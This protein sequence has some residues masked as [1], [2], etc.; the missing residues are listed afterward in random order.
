MHLFIPASSLHKSSI[1]Q[2]PKSLQ[3]LQ[4]W[5]QQVLSQVVKKS[6]WLQW[7]PESSGARPWWWTQSMPRA[8]WRQFQLGRRSPCCEGLAK[9]CPCPE[10]GEEKSSLAEKT[11]AFWGGRWRIINPQIPPTRAGWSKTSWWKDLCALGYGE[12]HSSPLPT[13]KAQ[14]ITAHQATPH[15]LILIQ[16]PH[17]L[18]CCHLLH[19][20][21]EESS[22]GEVHLF[23]PWGKEH[24]FILYAFDAHTSSMTS[25]CTHNMPARLDHI[26]SDL[27]VVWSGTFSTHCTDANRRETSFGSFQ[28]VTCAVLKEH[29]HNC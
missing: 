14:L 9:H 25:F 19:S 17:H 23:W 29:Q 6:R 18:L 7:S 15:Y 26:L 16:E 28:W 4:T 3:R 21:G 11:Y 20:P 12:D 10:Q 22:L 13:R 1:L 2:L 27:L 24:I 8:G 5:P